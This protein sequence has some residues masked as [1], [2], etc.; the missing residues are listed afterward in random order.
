MMASSTTDWLCDPGP[1]VLCFLTRKMELIITVLPMQ[2]HSE[3]QVNNAPAL[4][5][6]VPD[7][8]STQC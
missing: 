2:G 8:V 6:T 3:D 1:T 5:R 7:I 4:F